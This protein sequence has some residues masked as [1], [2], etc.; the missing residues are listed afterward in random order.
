MV[1]TAGKVQQASADLARLDDVLHYRPRLAL[2]ARQPAPVETFAAGH[3]SLQGVSFGYNP[4]E[5]PLIDELLARRRARPVGG[6]GRRLGQRQVDPGQARSPA[7]TS[8]AAARSASTATRSPNGAATGWPTSSRR[9]TRTSACSSG[10]LRDNVTLWDETV[11]RIARC[12]PPIARRGPAATSSKH[13]R[14]QHRRR[15]RG[16]RAQPQ[17]R[18]APAP[19]DRPRAGPGA[20]GAGA[21][22]GDQRASM[23]M[24]EDEI[25]SAVRRRGMTCVLVAHRLSTIRDCDE[26]IVLERGQHRRARHPRRADGGGR[27]PMPG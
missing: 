12:W 13:L 16:G 23:P 27:A 19:R 20:G 25:L 6:A 22:R 14:R 21:R 11:D 7:S 17:R 9:S 18:P 2:R 26:I 3:L 15:H 8:R 1:G 5:P 10:T 24:S 4:L